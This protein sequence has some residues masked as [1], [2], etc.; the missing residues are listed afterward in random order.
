MG[1]CAPTMP[2]TGAIFLCPPLSTALSPMQSSNPTEN[3][4]RPQDQLQNGLWLQG[5]LL[6]L[7]RDGTRSAP[8]RQLLLACS[9]GYHAQNLRDLNT[10]ANQCDGE[11]AASIGPLHGP[12]KLPLVVDACPEAPLT[13]APATTAMDCLA[14]VA[15]LAPAAPLVGVEPNPGPV[16]DKLL[17]AAVAGIAALPVV[18]PIPGRSMNPLKAYALLRANREATA[19]VERAN[20][21]WAKQNAQRRRVPVAGLIASTAATQAVEPNPGPPKGRR[22]AKRGK[23]KAKPKQPARASPAKAPSRA[24]TQAKPRG[25][26]GD[27]LQRSVPDVLDRTD[28]V[29]STSVDSTGGAITEGTVIFR[30]PINPIGTGK[31]STSG[32]N[33]QLLNY[34]A[35]L[36][37]NFDCTVTF[38]FKGTGNNYTTGTY[39][40]GF[41]MDPSDADPTVDRLIQQGGKTFTYGKGGRVTYAPGNRSKANSL[42]WCQANGSDPRLTQK[43]VFYVLSNESPS[44]YGNAGAVTGCIVPFQVHCHYRFRFRNPTFE[45]AV[46][47]PSGSAPSG[48]ARGLLPSFITYDPWG[49]ATLYSAPPAE[50]YMPGIVCGQWTT[51]GNTYGALAFPTDTIF[52][53]WDGVAVGGAVIGAPTGVFSDIVTGTWSVG[54]NRQSASFA[55]LTGKLALAS[56]KQTMTLVNSYQQQLNGSWLNMGASRSYAVWGA[57]ALSLPGSLTTDDP[58]WCITPIGSYVPTLA[59]RQWAQCGPAT[60]HGK[61]RGPFLSLEAKRAEAKGQQELADSTVLR[62]RLRQ[63]EAELRSPDDRESLSLETKTLP[64]GQRAPYPLRSYRP[65]SIGDR[66][67]Y[68]PTSPRAPPSPAPSKKVSRK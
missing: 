36:Y 5:F 21:R 23:S 29:L 59:E 48:Y 45:P 40:A 51:G 47:P 60:L 41:E 30:C 65:L 38:I 8:V 63:L 37:E 19:R 32:I 1:S 17:D 49:F 6:R 52:D 61:L 15:S 31:S 39:T 7:Y 9:H 35:A 68:E 13:P 18:G 57:I 42:Y 43:G 3:K 27:M 53:N 25:A 33:A 50:F 2:S 10:F 28:K 4:F 55:A 66:E 11:A 26:G 46:T 56:T 22:G 44:T 24:P 62:T 67:E 58:D 16:W 12:F 20:E 64:N 14:D 34:F 54:I